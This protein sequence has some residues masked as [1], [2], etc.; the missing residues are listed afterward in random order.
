MSATVFDTAARRPAR[1]G[2]TPAAHI[3]MIKHFAELVMAVGMMAL[4]VGSIAGAKLAIFVPRAV[5]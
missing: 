4:V 2:H 1:T 3:G 5:H